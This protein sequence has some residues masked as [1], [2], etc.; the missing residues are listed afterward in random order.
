[1]ERIT[2][3]KW[4]IEKV[5]STIGF[6]V[7]HLIVSFVKGEFKE[8]EASIYTTGEDFL[9]VEIN[10][11]INPASVSTGD[12]ARDIRL[13]GADFF[14]VKNFKAI[15]FSGN[16]F[17]DAGGDMYTLYGDLTMKG[18]TRKI[19]LNVEFGGIV[20]SPRGDKRAY[21]LVTGKI[22]R[23]DWGLTWRES[24]EYGGV[25]VGEEIFIHCEIELIKEPEQ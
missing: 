25:V 18:I 19:G 4:S 7:K 10:I 22:N 16:G 17:E 1:M 9:N 2:K 21:F 14:Y 11:S 5:H 24:M 3:S 15:N 12:V 13:K 23:K 6:K 8:Y 20:Q